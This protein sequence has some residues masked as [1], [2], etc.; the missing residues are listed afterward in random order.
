MCMLNDFISHL[1]KHLTGTE[2]HENTNIIRVHT[3]KLDLLGDLSFPGILKN[4]YHLVDKSKYED[5]QNIFNYLSS[6]SK[7][8]ENSQQWSIR[9]LKV[10][11][12][13][14]NVAL[15]I[16]KP[17]TFK[18]AIRDVIHLKA[19]YG[20]NSV[21]LKKKVVISSKDLTVHNLPEINLS[22]LKL[23]VLVK[24]TARLLQFTSNM[25]N[26]EEHLV[27][28]K[29]DNVRICFS[30]KSCTN[31]PTNKTILCGAVLDDTGSKDFTTTAEEFIRYCV[32]KCHG[33]I[34]VCNTIV[35]IQYTIFCN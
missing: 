22:E 20:S 7:L 19:K 25:Y 4:W 23:N 28:V 13:D 5:E 29:D 9:I 15:Y 21:Q 27:N 33:L 11:H 10:L 12:N 32:L 6:E 3:R 2:P 34:T 18:S 17:S 35:I 16:D 8:I 24:T 26:C 31:D 14:K 30:L 1:Y